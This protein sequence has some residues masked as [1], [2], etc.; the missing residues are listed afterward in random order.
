MASP[1]LAN[2]ELVVDVDSGQV[3][4]G[5]E[6]TAKWYPAAL[7]TLMTVYVALNAVRDGRVSMD[8]PFVVSNRAANMPPSRMG[9]Q[10]G[11]QLISTTPSSCWWSSRPTTSR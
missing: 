8:T 7:T 1:A 10:P 6:L 4:L 2:P 11:V 9:F 5:R 3:L